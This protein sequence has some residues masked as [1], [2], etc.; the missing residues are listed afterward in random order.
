MYI[1]I[2]YVVEEK[3]N[4]NYIFFP[5]GHGKVL[6]TTFL[7]FSKSPTIYMNILI[8]ARKITFKNYLASK[9]GWVGI[10][11]DSWATSP[12]QHK[13]LQ[14]GPS[15]QAQQCRAPH[16]APSTWQRSRGSCEGGRAKPGT[17]LRKPHQPS[18]PDKL[19]KKMCPTSNLGDTANCK[20]PHCTTHAHHCPP[21]LLITG[22]QGV[23]YRLME[24]SSLKKRRHSPHNDDC[25]LKR[26]V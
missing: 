21:N 23:E 2:I 11:A 3:F 5:L 7:W 20:G 19:P 10:S 8:R 22:A 13:L 18:H 15:T 24:R 12:A 9:A 26:W 17:S 25:W 1:K 16:P 4:N 14:P 6:L